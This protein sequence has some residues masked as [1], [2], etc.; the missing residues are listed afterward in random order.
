M[1]IGEIQTRI[2]GCRHHNAAQEQN[3][4]EQNET[5]GHH[6]GHHGGIIDTVRILLLFILL[7][8]CPKITCAIW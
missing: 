4:Q 2:E 1:S 5:Q 7:R 3:G 6:N 8:N